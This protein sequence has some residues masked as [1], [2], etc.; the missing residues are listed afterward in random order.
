MATL[1]DDRTPK[2][3]IVGAGLAGA[4]IA[5]LLDRLG[6]KVFIFEIILLT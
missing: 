3:A 6:F 4:L 2:I 5:A 1:E